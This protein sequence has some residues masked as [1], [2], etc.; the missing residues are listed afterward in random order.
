MIR[1]HGIAEPE[2]PVLFFPGKK[3]VIQQEIRPLAAQLIQLRAVVQVSQTSKFT[4]EFCRQLLSIL[5][6]HPNVRHFFTSLSI[7]ASSSILPE[8]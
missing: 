4:S 7:A 5:Q 1:M 2:R 6:M 3:T 8:Y